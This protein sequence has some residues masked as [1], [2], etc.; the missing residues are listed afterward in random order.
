MTLFIALGDLHGQVKSLERLELLQSHY[1]DAITVFIGDYIDSFTE[2]H[3]FELL[4]HI[5]EMQVANPKQTVVLGG[6]HEQGAQEFFDDPS[7][8][9]WLQ[10][11]GE[12][13]LMVASGDEYGGDPYQEREDLL[14]TDFGLIDW[15]GQLPLIYTAEKLCFVHAGLDLTLESPVTDTS[16][17]DKLWSREKY[18]YDPTEWGTFNHNKLPL[19][20]ITGHTPNEKISGIYQNE[21][22]PEK[23]ESYHSPIY[24]IEYP[25]EMPRYLMDG[26]VGEADPDLLGNVA[27]FDGETGLLIDAIED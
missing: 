18:W 16:D 27:V 2:N 4:K 23:F 14:D 6:N 9:G 1:P 17:Y 7:S 13:T 19:S 3:G 11:G 10:F 12:D 24:T 15:M 22:K 8:D 20:I 25:G 26:A 21:L 5:H